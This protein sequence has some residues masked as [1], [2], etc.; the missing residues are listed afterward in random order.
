[1]VVPHWQWAT[2]VIV[3][4]VMSIKLA[5]RWYDFCGFSE[6]VEP[7]SRPWCQS[8]GLIVFFVLRIFP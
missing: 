6:M 3:M 5:H 8:E 4:R 1:M 7:D 2:T